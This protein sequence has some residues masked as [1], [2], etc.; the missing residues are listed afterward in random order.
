MASYSS[1]P[2]Y[3]SVYWNKWIFLPFT[4]LSIVCP[5]DSFKKEKPFCDHFILN[6]KVMLWRLNHTLV[7]LFL[8]FYAVEQISKMPVLTRKNMVR[9]YWPKLLS[10]GR[11]PGFHSLFHQDMCEPVALNLICCWKSPHLFP[12]QQASPLPKKW[13]ITVQTK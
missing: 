4:S 5:R 2:I 9:I 3:A 11:N 1:F 10:R 12:V 6:H 13:T 8:S 7:S